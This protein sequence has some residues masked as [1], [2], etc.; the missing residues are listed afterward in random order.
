MKSVANPNATYVSYWDNGED[1]WDDCCS[2]LECQKPDFLRAWVRRDQ[3]QKY[4]R[5][6]DSGYAPPCCH[7]LDAMSSNKGLLP[8]CWD[9]DE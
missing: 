8:L 9:H 2:C 1:G 6:D 7:H 5:A 4:H 3:K